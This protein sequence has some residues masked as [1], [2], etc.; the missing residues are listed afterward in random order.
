MLVLSRKMNETII[1][2]DN[3]RVTVVGIRG[4]QVRLGIEAPAT[5]GICRDELRVPVRVGGERTEPP[6]PRAQ[7]RQP[8]SPGRPPENDPR[9][10]SPG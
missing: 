2:A 1:I 9:W 6:A 4:S 10:G 3:I 7:S 5:V 8:V